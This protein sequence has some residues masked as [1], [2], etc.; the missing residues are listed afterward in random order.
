MRT[1]HLL[2]CF[3]NSNGICRRPNYTIC[4]WKS[5]IIVLKIYTP[6]VVIVVQRL[7]V[8]LNTLQVILGTIFTE[9]LK[10]TNWSSRSGL[11]PTRTTPPC[12]NNTTLR[13]RLYAQ[14]KGSNV[15]NPICLTLITVSHNNLLVAFCRPTNK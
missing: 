13:N 11:N 15:T 14:R 8:P 1:V 10:E 5:K 6:V 3:G 7:N 9:A 12:Y 4:F 2:C